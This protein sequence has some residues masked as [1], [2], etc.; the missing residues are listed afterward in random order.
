MGFFLLIIAG[1]VAW[2]FISAMNRAKRRMAY[3]DQ[4]SAARELSALQGEP[5]LMPTWLMR[6]GHLREFLARVEVTL[7]SR[8]V[9]AQFV[10][11]V[12]A[13][14][15]EYHRIMHLVALLERRNGGLTAQV[16]AAADYV[17]DKWVAQELHR[18]GLPTWGRNK[19]EV[20]AFITEVGVVLKDRSIAPPFF[21]AV[22]DEP[23]SIEKLMQEV[24]K[25][26]RG[27]ASRE[28]Q[29]MV[30]AQVVTDR[31]VVLPKEEQDRLWHQD[32]QDVLRAASDA[33]KRLRALTS[34][35]TS[36]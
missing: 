4:Q 22:M 11:R 3:A 26:E 28:N 32:F 17:W 31:W 9:P 12:L 19:S 6:P 13:D 36:T 16:T 14:D 24:I 2:F 27:G 10:E 23:D 1:L 25:A 7:R 5:E 8:E 20:D 33:T 30:A 18:V 35:P 21:R 29:V 34:K 15:L